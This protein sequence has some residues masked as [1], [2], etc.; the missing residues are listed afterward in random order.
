MNIDDYSPS[1]AVVFCPH[2]GAP[3]RFP[4][5]HVEPDEECTQCDRLRDE[6]V[7]GAS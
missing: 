6:P 7:E 5:W 2:C 4:E 3:Y 1:D